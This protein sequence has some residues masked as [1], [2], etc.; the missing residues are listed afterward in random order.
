MT[1]KI[2]QPALDD[3]HSFYS[4][5]KKINKINKKWHKGNHPVVC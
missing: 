5:H 1:L 2:D 3:V 4:T